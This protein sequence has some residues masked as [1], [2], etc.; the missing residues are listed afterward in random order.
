M[1]SPNMQ[2]MSFIRKWAARERLDPLLPQAVGQLGESLGRL[3]RDLLA[4]DA[5]PQGLGIGEQLA[6][7]VEIGRIG[8]PGQ[9]EAVD[10]LGRAGEVGVDLEAVHVADDQQR[11]VIQVLAVEQQ[12]GVGVLQ[13]LVLALVFPAE[14][15]AHPHVGPAL[16]AVGL[17]HA[18]LEG[19]PGAVRVGLGRLGLAEQFA[20]VEKMLLAGAPLGEVDAL[21]L[22]DELLRGHGTAFP[23]A[24]SE[25][26]SRRRGQSP[27]CRILP[28]VGSGCHTLDVRR[29]AFPRL[30]IGPADGL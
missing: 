5:R 12:L 6:E 26:L 29:P 24:R 10:L 4:G 21:P 28:P 1:S 20:Q 19:V 27:T 22:G 15:A 16:A 7:D 3:D 13:V 30:E 23:G 25:Q 2:N 14:V 11:R 18:V 17:L 8:Q 9:V